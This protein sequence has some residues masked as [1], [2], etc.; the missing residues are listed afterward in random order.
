[1]ITVSTGFKTAVK[2]QSRYARSYAKIYEYTDATRTTVSQTGTIYDND[3]LIDWE[4]SGVVD[5]GKT[6]MRSATIKTLSNFDLANKEIELFGGITLADDSVEYISLGNFIV[7]KPNTSSNGLET[8]YE[9]NDYML[10]FQQ[11]YVTELTYPKTALQIVQ[12]ICT[13]LSVT[14]GNDDFFN[15]DLSIP[16]PPDTVGLSYRDVLKW[17]AELSLTFCKIG[18]DNKLYFKSPEITG[19]T[20][21]GNSY[22]DL[23]LEQLYGPINKITLES[24][25]DGTIVEEKDDE[26]ITLNGA[27]SLDFIDNGLLEQIRDT[28][29]VG[30]LAQINGTS[31]YPFNMKWTNWLYLETG[32]SITVDDIADVSYNTIIM[33][34]QQSFNGALSGII[35]NEAPTQVNS[36]YYG[37]TQLSQIN[38]RKVG[39]GE[40]ISKINQTPEEITIQASKISLEG[41]TTINNNFTID[42]SGNAT[43]GQFVLGSK[44]NL[45]LNS[46]GN[47]G[48]TGWSYS[49]VYDDGSPYPNGSKVSTG[50]NAKGAI[51]DNYFLLAAI[52]AEGEQS[53]QKMSVTVVAE[54]YYT[55]SFRNRCYPL[56]QTYEEVFSDYNYKVVVDFGATQ[57]TLLDNTDLLNATNTFI[58]NKS[59]FSIPTGVTSIDIY[60]IAD[61]SL[62]VLNQTAFFEI[63][64]ILFDKENFARPWTVNNAEDYL[65]SVQI[66]PSEILI[67]GEDG[68]SLSGMSAGG[69]ETTGNVKCSDVKASQLFATG[70]SSIGGDLD[71]TLDLEVQQDAIVHGDLYSAENATS[72]QD[73]LNSKIDTRLVAEYTFAS[74]GTSYTFTGLDFNAD[75]GIYEVYIYGDGAAGFGASP[76]A[77]TMYVNGDTTDTNYRYIRNYLT[78]AANTVASGNA[79]Y[80][81]YLYRYGGM[82]VITLTLSE[83]YAMTYGNNTLRTTAIIESLSYMYFHNV[84]TANITSLTFSTGSNM[85]IGTKI[86]IYKK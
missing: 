75:G 24:T 70:D 79:P 40:I 47:D 6:S 86:K 21:D 61:A 35:K 19:E 80:I 31:Y 44:Y 85:G 27:T 69:I 73:Q 1:M 46:N 48:L 36:D 30:M 14:L 8:I 18:N 29:I 57:T 54:E 55:L 77:I 3:Y 5:F 11:P 51:N 68:T 12:E 74:A 63:A 13:N 67:I 4:I 25:K 23:K 10:K 26:S 38:A 20:I 62:G 17:V 66:S 76:G 34:E 28:A 71:V 42:S 41:Y 59:T 53:I 37:S 56:G 9:A 33:D 81:G 78:G 7:K 82:N 84:V 52:G 45:F 72:I 15:Y 16:Q 49:A 60:F 39:S 50:G 58:K 32:D 2:G 65:S 43:I 64:D 83:G 22:Y